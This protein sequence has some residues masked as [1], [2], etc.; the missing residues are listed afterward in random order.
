MDAV[1]LASPLDARDQAVANQKYA[2]L[3]E[4]APPTP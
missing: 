4:L 1:T 3:I 2:K